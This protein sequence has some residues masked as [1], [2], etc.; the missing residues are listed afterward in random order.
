MPADLMLRLA[1]SAVFA[2]V[3]AGLASAAHVLAGGTV[4]APTLALGLAVGLGIGL[5][6]T[7]RERSY[8]VILPLLGA[9]QVM[10]HLLFS[11]LP[12]TIL[13]E[14]GTYAGHH[15]LSPD[16]GML[17]FHAVATLLTAWWLDRGES[18]LW[19]LLRRLVADVVWFLYRHLVPM[20]RVERIPAGAEHDRPL[21]DAVPLWLSHA[22]VRRGPPVG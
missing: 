16:T 13:F 9:G 10:S 3:C 4:T 15:A 17:V 8:A 21:G 5:P 19:A 1:R 2:V 20:E 14:T 7:G 22:V 6:A 12:R 11:G 18:A